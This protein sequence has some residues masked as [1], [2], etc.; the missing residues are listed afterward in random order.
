[1]FISLRS[2]TVLLQM[3]LVHLDLIRM[4]SYTV[5]F[6][7]YPV[8]LAL[9][10][11]GSYTIHGMQAPVYWLGIWILLN[12]HG[13]CYKLSCYPNVFLG[14]HTSV[15]FCTRLQMSSWWTVYYKPGIY[16]SSFPVAMMNI[17]A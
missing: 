5:L 13:P 11:M 3:Y 16:P 7:M 1:M 10:R 8:Y 12:E 15:I 6:Q 4:G 17:V 14:D 9:I 2:Y